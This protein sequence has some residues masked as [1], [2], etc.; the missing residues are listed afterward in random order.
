MTRSE[1]LDDAVAMG[2]LLTIIWFAITMSAVV[3]MLTD[4]WLVGACP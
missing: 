4:A 2:V 1:K 3:L